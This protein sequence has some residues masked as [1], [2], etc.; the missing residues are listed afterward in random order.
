[1]IR[2]ALC[3]LRDHAATWIGAFMVAAACGFIGGWGVSLAATAKTYPNMQSSAVT[4]IAFSMIAAVPVAAQTANLAV[5]AQRRSYALWQLANASPRQVRAVVLGQ[6]ATVALSGALCGTLVEAA[7]FEPLFPWVFSSPFY[8][9][10]DQVVLEVGLPLMPAVWL[11]VAAVFLVGGLR[12]A[13]NAAKTP[14]VAVLREPE[15]ARRGMAWTRTLLC[16]VLAFSTWQVA[17]SLSGSDLNSLSASLFVPL[18]ATATLAAAAPVALPALLGAWTALVSR[19]RWSVWFLARRAAR[20]GLAA[21]TSVEAPVVVGFGVVAGVFSLSNLLGAFVVSRSVVG[22]ST[23]L[24]WTS[25]VL[26]LGGPVLIAVVGAAA[27]MA[28][29][30][31]ARV[32]DVALLVACGAS[33][34]TVLASSVCEALIHAV[35]A[36]LAGMLC[37]IVSNAA[38]AFALGLPPLEGLSFAEGAAVPLAGL[39]L[40]LVAELAPTISVLRKGAVPVLAARE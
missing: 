30:S 5:T 4:V 15:E 34:R 22:Y 27:S 17:A 10:I 12:G 38:V 32:R 26:L 25:S 36:T 7:S 6:I 14:P 9:P 40:V 11:A 31:R 33:F 18:L 21:S 35:T 23:S 28:M 37:I 2:L 39:V 1:M 20:F 13:C 29:S 19:G 24:D 8:Q 3:D 16:A